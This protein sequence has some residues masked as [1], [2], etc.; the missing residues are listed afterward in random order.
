MKNMTTEQRHQEL[1]ESLERMGFEK[2]SD[3]WMIF[4][5]K[6]MPDVKFD[7]SVTANDPFWYMDRIFEIAKEQGKNE[8]RT[9]LAG[10][11]CGNSRNA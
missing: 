1:T 3:T 8:L 5:H 7:F 10:L 2:T 11:L 4:T 6:M 9:D